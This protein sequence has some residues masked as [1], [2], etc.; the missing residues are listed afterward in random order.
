MTDA[1]ATRDA[2]QRW[3]SVWKTAWEARD[4]DAIVTL[5]HPDALFSTEPFRVPFRGSSGVRS[6]VGQAFDEEREPRVWVGEPVVD[7][8]RA[9]IEWWA[10][11][12]ENGRE[13]TL[14]GTSMLRFDADGLVIEQRDAWNQADGLSSPP[15]GWGA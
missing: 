8:A 1:V 5:Y 7:G 11:L 6:Y 13:I 4:T 14:A 12:E 2:A 9:A 15:D 3:A 10:A